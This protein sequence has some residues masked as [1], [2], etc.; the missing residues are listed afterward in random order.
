MFNYE[1]AYAELKKVYGLYM[2]AEPFRALFCP[3]KT[4]EVVRR[5]A[6]GLATRY[7]NTMSARVLGASVKKLIDIDDETGVVLETVNYKKGVK[8]KVELTN[9]GLTPVRCSLMTCLAVDMLSKRPKKIGY[10]GNGRINLENCKAISKLIG[11]HIAIIRGSERDRE[12]NYDKFR[13]VARF[14]YVDNTEDLSLLNRCDVVIAC[15]STADEADMIEN[16]LLR[17]VPLVIALDSG[18]L[19]GETFRTERKLYTDHVEQLLAH[20]K[21]E[22]PRDK[23]VHKHEQLKKDKEKTPKLV[24]LFGIALADLVTA[25]HFIRGDFEW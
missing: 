24:S 7:V 9:V 12:K 19:L 18:Y 23:E 25:K 6:E 11:K 22:F 4:V 1:A 20:Y 10:I 16:E 15:T 14:V 2:D 17:D 5:N 21:D 8:A 3:I 13:D